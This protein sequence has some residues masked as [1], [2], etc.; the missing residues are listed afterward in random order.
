MGAIETRNGRRL[1]W[2]G[3]LTIFVSVAGWVAVNWSRSGDTPAILA[4]VG[5]IGLW[6]GSAGVAYG[7]RLRGKLGPGEA[8]RPRNGV[9]VLP[10]FILLAVFWR[11]LDTFSPWWLL[12]LPTTT[13]D[14]VEGVGIPQWAALAV[15]AVL[16]VPQC[17]MVI[18]IWNAVVVKL[19]QEV[20]GRRS[21]IVEVIRG[22]GSGVDTTGD[23]PTGTHR[24]NVWVGQA[25]AAPG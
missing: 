9:L 8:I 10:L 25:V 11:S 5:M 22:I 7:D 13:Y 17:F 23:A 6:A 18:I 2:L 15:T 24:W 21:P 12:A 1:A 14:L 3:Y 19:V 4:V 20:F 16:A